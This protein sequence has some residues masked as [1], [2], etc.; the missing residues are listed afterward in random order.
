MLRLAPTI[1]PIALALTASL[2]ACGTATTQLPRDLPSVSPAG[3]DLVGHIPPG[4]PDETASGERDLDGD[5]IPDCWRAHRS[6]GGG[7]FATTVTVRRGCT[8][9]ARTL[10][11]VAP[12]LD[13]FVEVS[14]PTV[15]RRYPELLAGTLDL[16][17]GAEHLRA[18]DGDDT[19]AAPAADGT[20]RW[21]AQF[22]DGRPVGKSLPF[23]AIH[24]WDPHWTPGTP[25]LPDSQIA[26]V[27]RPRRDRAPRVAGVGSG[28]FDGR[29]TPERLLVYRARLHGEVGPAGSCERWDLYSTGHA[30][31]TGDRHA[32]A[33]AWIWA[34]RAAPSPTRASVRTVSCAMGLV[35]L[36]PARPA[37]D[38][39]LLVIAPEL[40]RFGRVPL[41]SADW[42]VNRA[43]RQLHFGDGV[44]DLI[45]LRDKLLVP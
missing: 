13:L 6:R 37:D 2:T 5:G 17:F 9:T 22:A 38:R 39:E 14:I 45:D 16:L 41:G 34:S 19:L 24:A 3:E 31:A 18:L 29:S 1:A 10:S 30:V 15:W 32:D 28:G 12:M 4:A 25:E 23:D 7:W 42:S 20:L 27:D 26:V 35:F 44:A 21:L 36:E 33:S 43:T 11:H 40:G 8:G